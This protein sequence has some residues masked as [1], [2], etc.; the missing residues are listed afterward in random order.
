MTSTNRVP[1]DG[2]PAE[3]AQTDVTT[4]PTGQAVV[5]GRESRRERRLRRRA[6][7][8]AR[9]TRARAAWVAT[10]VDAELPEEIQDHVPGWAS[11]GRGR[12]LLAGAAVIALLVWALIFIVI[13]GL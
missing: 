13:A 10:T 1:E 8:R 2:T 5:V 3:H 11:T 6:A 12:V 7:H 4:E 9:M